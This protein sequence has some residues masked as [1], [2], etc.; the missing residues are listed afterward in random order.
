MTDPA[1]PRFSEETPTARVEIITGTLRR[2]IARSTL[3]GNSRDLSE[4]GI[5]E[6][7]EQNG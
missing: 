5:S 2:K 6:L 7:A 1:I 4:Q 3:Y